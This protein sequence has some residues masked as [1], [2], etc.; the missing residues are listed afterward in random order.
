MSIESNIHLNRQ[1]YNLHV[2]SFPSIEVGY[3]KVSVAPPA[4][5]SSSTLDLCSGHRQF[6]PMQNNS[7]KNISIVNTPEKFIKK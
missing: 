2:I 4:T 6:I 7:N 1:L 3:F 5:T